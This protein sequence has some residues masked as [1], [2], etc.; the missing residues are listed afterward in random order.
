ML[1][2]FACEREIELR[3][4]C[5][6]D[7][8]DGFDEGSERL[9]SVH[10]L[11]H[12]TVVKIYVGFFILILIILYFTFAHHTETVFMIGICAFYGLMYFGTPWVLKRVAREDQQEVRWREFLSK[13]FDTNTGKI[14]GRTVLVQ[15]CI[16]P[17]A[18]SVCILGICL[19]IMNA[20]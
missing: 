15:I 4:R 8:E 12:P 1:D 13:P 11:L 3:R 6:T 7:S 14:S 16:V 17:A 18:L 9:G 10:T 19:A 5:E 20:R 2:E